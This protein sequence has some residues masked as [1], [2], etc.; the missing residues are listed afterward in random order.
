[1]SKKKTVRGFGYYE[2]K[3]TYGSNCS[4][5]ESSSAMEAKVWLGVDNA[6]P[7]IMASDA[8]KLGIYLNPSL[9]VTGWV[10]Y[11]IPSE[12]SLSTRMHL[13]QEQAKEL[14]KRLEVF[15]ETGGL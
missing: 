10:N 6:N 11:N 3:D 8:E 13:N 12:V 5:Q 4:L 14:I 7:R 2:F 15:V 1:M 9:P